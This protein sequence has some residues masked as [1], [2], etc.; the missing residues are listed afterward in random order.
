MKYVCVRLRGLNHLQCSFSV[1]CGGWFMPRSCSGDEYKTVKANRSAAVEQTI[2][3]WVCLLAVSPMLPPF[4]SLLSMNILPPCINVTKLCVI[5]TNFSCIV[6]VLSRSSITC[7]WIRIISGYCEE[8][9]GICT[10]S[11]WNCIHF[12]P[13]Q[14]FI[15]GKIINDNMSSCLTSDSFNFMPTYELCQGVCHF[16]DKH[17]ADIYC[18]KGD[19]SAFISQVKSRS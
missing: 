16:S 4:K 13:L 5:W 8:S 15:H 2:Y 17:N 3:L 19:R 11:I 14:Q 18:H 9:V 10:F 7:T 1:L 12:L 6:A